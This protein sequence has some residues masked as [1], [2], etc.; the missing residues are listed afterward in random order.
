MK[1]YLLIFN[2][3]L[4]FNSYSQSKNSIYLLIDKKDTLIKKN[5]NKKNSSNHYQLFFT[6]KKKIKKNNTPI[7][8][9]KVWVAD[10]KYD[11]Y[12]YERDS[13]EFSFYKTEDKSINKKHLE[14]LTYIKKREKFL[15]T[16]NLLFKYNIYFIEPINKNKF[17]IRKAYP[18]FYE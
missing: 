7:I 10:T 11:Y 14:S 4:L 15:N 18:I 3:F 1:K 5:E 17:I 9:N 8:K 6:E 16:S 13:Y 2:F 12:V